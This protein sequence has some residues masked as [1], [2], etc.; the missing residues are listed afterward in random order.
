VFSQTTSPPD[1]KIKEHLF[2]ASFS[3]EKSRLCG[4]VP[5]KRPK[6]K[7][8]NMVNGIEG[9]SAG[10]YDCCAAILTVSSKVSPWI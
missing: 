10:L 2:L 9:E 6:R 1:T 7:D 4:K 3:R 8:K 5:R